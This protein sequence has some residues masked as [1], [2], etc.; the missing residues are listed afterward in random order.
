[1][2]KASSFN[3]GKTKSEI[4]NPLS[5]KVKSDSYNLDDSFQAYKNQHTTRT[6][7]NS[8]DESPIKKGKVKTKRKC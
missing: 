2:Q 8:K 7:S 3:Q 4:V 6:E 1:M 5:F